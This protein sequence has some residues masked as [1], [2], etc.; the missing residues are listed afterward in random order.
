MAPAESTI[1]SLDCLSA[2]IA[3]QWI[4]VDGCESISTASAP[5]VVF[6]AS[7]NV[8]KCTAQPS[9]GIFYNPAVDFLGLVGDMNQFNSAFADEG[10]FL[11]VRLACPGPP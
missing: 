6:M 4:N 9:T 8:I 11:V 2:E 3:A 7:D 10:A 1:W 5:R